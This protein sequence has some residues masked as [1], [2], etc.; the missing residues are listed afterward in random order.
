[1][2]TPCIAIC[3]VGLKETS[4]LWLLRYESENF[5]EQMKVIWEDVKELYQ[6]LYGFVRYRL[7]QWYPGDFVN[8]D[9]PIPA[10]LL[11]TNIIFTTEKSI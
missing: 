2:L 9:D 7:R 11:G 3:F 4:E 8:D 1:M 5:K 6:K 10:H